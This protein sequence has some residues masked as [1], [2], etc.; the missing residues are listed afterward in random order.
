LL[1]YISENFT[2]YFSFLNLFTYI[3]FRTGGAILTALF[4]SLIFGEPL[5][6]FL[7]SLQP[8]GQPI[9]LDGPERHIIE[10]AGT[11]TMGGVLILSSI[12]VSVFIWSD[13]TNIFIWI[14]LFSTFSFGLIGLVDDYKKTRSLTSK[15][16][17]VSTRILVQTILG[18]VIVFLIYSF[19][20]KE[21][22]TVISF[23]FFKNLFLNLGLLFFPFGI[24]LIIGSANAVNLTDGLDGLA[25]VPV[26][27]VALSFAFISYVCGNLIFSDYLQIRYIFGSGELAVM[28]GA[29][30][31][32]ALGFL[33]FN[34]PPAKVFMGDTGSLSMGGTLGTLSLITKHEIVLAIIGGLFVLETLS[35][36]IQVLSFKL[37][38]KRIFRMAPLHHH[39]EKQGWAE[40]TIVIRFWI[41]TIILALIGLA[42]LKIR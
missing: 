14:T 41:I 5:I 17:K 22:N 10:K 31:G 13:L 16:L 20:P 37:T 11:P 1:V 26:L 24:F 21:F 6:K 12:L 9:R 15:G 35:V 36:I 7:S 28:C 25:I 4:F 30:V 38:G 42:T 23:P 34:A 32:S 3:T 8:S 2:N 18:F 33:W 29:L 39:F 19:L 27:I 40:S